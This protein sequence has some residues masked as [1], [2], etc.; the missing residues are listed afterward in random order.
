ML[1]EYEGLPAHTDGR[2][3]CVPDLTLRDPQNRKMR[4]ITI[5]AGLS[6]IMF[7]YRFQ[8]ELDNFEHVIY[9]KNGE[10]GGTWL[11]NRYPNCAW[12]GKYSR[13]RG[14]PNFRLTHLRY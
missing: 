1:K 6:G 14:V 10:I 3:Y 8:R 11:E 9:E 7:A 13:R 4:I 5:G 2:G 12:D